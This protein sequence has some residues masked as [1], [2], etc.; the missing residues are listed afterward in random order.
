MSVLVTSRPTVEASPVPLPPFTHYVPLPTESPGQRDALI[1]A[2]LMFYKLMFFFSFIPSLEGRKDRHPWF[3][4][5]APLTFSRSA[6][7][8]GSAMCLLI[9]ASWLGHPAEVPL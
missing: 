1:E 8:V 2:L 7:Q 3:E 6:S 4:D 5:V 9:H